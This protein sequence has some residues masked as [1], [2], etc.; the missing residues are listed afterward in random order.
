MDNNIYPLKEK[1]LTFTNENIGRIL[2][3][4]RKQLHITQQ[5]L[6][7]AIGIS[8][9]QIQKYENGTNRISADRLY[10][11]GILLGVEV[12]YFFETDNKNQK[13]DNK[14][15]NKPNSKLDKNI[16]IQMNRVE[17]NVRTALVNLIKIIEKPKSG[18][19]Q[20]I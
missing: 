14:K 4:R 10:Y 12:S 1:H 7:D 9:Q 8:Y 16:S 19:K 17:P 6:A 15:S 20:N 13:S 11:L 3:H 18:K 5:G 2:R